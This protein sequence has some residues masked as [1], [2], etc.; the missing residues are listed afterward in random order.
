MVHIH[1]RQAQAIGM[2]SRVAQMDQSW[3]Q[4]IMVATSTLARI[5]ER[6]GQQGVCQL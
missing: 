4:G 1:Y 5:L 6:L 2:D 3:L